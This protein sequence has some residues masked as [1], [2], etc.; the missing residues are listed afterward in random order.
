M[1]KKPID[2]DAIGLIGKSSVY[3]HGDEKHR[4]K[5][6]NRNNWAFEEANRRDIY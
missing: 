3:Q 5:E 1:I 6:L 4:R 2:F